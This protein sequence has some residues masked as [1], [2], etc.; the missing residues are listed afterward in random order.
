[1]HLINIQVYWKEWGLIIEKWEYEESHRHTKLHQAGQMKLKNT[2]NHW[3]PTTMPSG[4][5]EKIVV[6]ALLTNV[7]LPEMDLH[8]HDV[9]EVFMLFRTLFTLSNIDENRTSALHTC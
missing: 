2:H 6:P 9:C 5:L 7:K 4:E 3:T 8:T 1:M